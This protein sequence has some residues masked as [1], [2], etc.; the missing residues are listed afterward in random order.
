MK[1]LLICRHAKSSWDHPLLTDQLR[2][3]AERGERDAPLMAKRMLANRVIPEKILTSNAV[4][5]VQTAERYLEIFFKEDPE[6]EKTPDLYHASPKAILEKIRQT[7]DRINSLFIFGHNPGFTD[8]I[9]YLGENLDNLPTAAVF[10]FYFQTNHWMDIQPENASFWL[11]DFP[12]NKSPK[13]S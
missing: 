3:L 13:I 10:G 7:P 6:F 5:A 9:N 2:P 12:K 8:L 11:Y 4:R 1:K